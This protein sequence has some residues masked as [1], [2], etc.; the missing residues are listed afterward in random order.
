MARAPAIQ[1]WLRCLTARACAELR[2]PTGETPL[3]AAMRH[4][5]PRSIALILAARAAVDRKSGPLH[6]APLRVAL[7]RGHVAAVRMLCIFGADRSAPAG[8]HGAS[9]V[10]SSYPSNRLRL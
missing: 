8:S 5:D 4:G 10:R 1:R 3:L 2:T 9:V 6:I 7:E